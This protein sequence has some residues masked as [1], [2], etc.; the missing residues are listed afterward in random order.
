MTRVRGV[1]IALCLLLALPA[2]AQAA[3]RE[4]AVIDRRI[5]ITMDDLPW[6]GTR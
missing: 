5:A 2:A 1:L 6:A 4:G 3:T